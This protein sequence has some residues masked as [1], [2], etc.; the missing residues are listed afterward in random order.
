MNLNHWLI[1]RV[2]ILY[3]KQDQRPNLFIINICVKDVHK[4]HGLNLLNILF[5]LTYVLAQ[6]LGWDG[7]GGC[8]QKSVDMSWCLWQDNLACVTLSRQKPSL[9]LLRSHFDLGAVETMFTR[10]PCVQGWLLPFNHIRWREAYLFGF[11][12]PSK[13]N[14]QA[15]WQMTENSILC[16]YC[17]V[18]YI[19]QFF[20]TISTCQCCVRLR[21]PNNTLITCCNIEFL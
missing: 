7:D 19:C 6:Q 8:V 11:W 14:E 18:W 15:L 17:E 9:F 5:I 13:E 1:I 12:E 4:S 3:I 10:D 21:F 20:A 2:K 16:L